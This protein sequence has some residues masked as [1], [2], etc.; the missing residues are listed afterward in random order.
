MYL[1]SL[2]TFM[3]GT[4]LLILGWFTRKGDGD[5]TA[6][7]RSRGTWMMIGGLAAIGGAVLDYLKG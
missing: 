6:Q 3:L 2:F 7:T 1:Y 5:S 4:A